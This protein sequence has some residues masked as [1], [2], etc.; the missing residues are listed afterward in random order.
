MIDSIKGVLIPDDN[1]KHVTGLL[2]V[3]G[4][5]DNILVRVE[6]LGSDYYVI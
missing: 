2:Q 6:E 5:R 1:K 4:D 3:F